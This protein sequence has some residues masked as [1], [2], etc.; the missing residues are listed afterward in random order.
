MEFLSGHHSRPCRPAEHTPCL[1]VEAAISSLEVV[2]Y[3]V[4]G[5]GIWTRVE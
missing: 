5:G 2:G 1:F 3:Y 4:E